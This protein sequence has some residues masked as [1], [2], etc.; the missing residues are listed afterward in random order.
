MGA[1]VER[2]PRNDFSHEIGHVYPQSI[3]YRYLLLKAFE[4]W[5]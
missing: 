5:L 4:P 2:G 3:R 1:N